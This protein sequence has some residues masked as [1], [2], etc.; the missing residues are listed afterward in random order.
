MQHARL[1]IVIPAWNESTQLGKVIDQLRKLNISGI[2][3]IDILVV[4]DGSTDKT[5]E[6]ATKRG[7]LVISHRIN[8]GLGVALGTGFSYAKLNRYDFLVTFDADGQH[9]PRDISKLLEPLVHRIADVSIGSRLLVSQGMPFIR[10]AVNTLSNLTTY[11]LFGIWTTDSQSGLRCFNRHSI[12]S[13]NIKSQRM[14]VSSEI[15][16][17]IA[18]LKLRITEIPIKPVYTKYS[19]SKGQKIS[20]APNVA[21]KLFLQKFI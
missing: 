10:K 1:L 12:E 14:E 4:N 21:Y 19:L 15:F 11:M 7:V 9:N 13:I 17:E 16:K 18:R 20:N 2:K 5:V 6:V 3:K 8:R